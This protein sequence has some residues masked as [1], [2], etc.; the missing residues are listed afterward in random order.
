MQNAIPAGTKFRRALMMMQALAV[1]NTSIGY[2]DIKPYVS[3]GK[4]GKQ[5]HRASGAAAIKR[6]A[7]KARNSRI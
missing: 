3:R 4:G 6:A 2:Q 5:P 1:A 7:K